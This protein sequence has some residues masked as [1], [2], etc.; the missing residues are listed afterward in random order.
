[1][2]R[3]L[4]GNAALLD[5]VLFRQTKVF[6]GGH[7]AEHRGSMIGRRRGADAGGDVIVAGEDVCNQRAEH[8]EGSAMAEPA[9]ELHVELDL[10]K[11]DMTRTLDHDLDALGPG[12][13]GQLAEGFQLRQ[14]RGI[15]GIGETTW[16][17]AVSQAEGDIVLPHDVT[18]VFKEI[19]HRILLTV[20]QHPLGQ[21]AAAARDDSDQPVLDQRQMLPEHTG[22]KGE[23]VHALLRL[24]LEILENHIV[25]QVL[26][27]APDDHGIDRH[28]ADGRPGVPDE[29]LPAHID[30]APC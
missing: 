10:I 19:V 28:R 23:I 4:V 20:N 12:P 25:G 7:V 17:Q 8:V 24:V 21:Q 27:L 11:G 18:D 15:A 16:T 1:M 3:D 5:I 9:L 14:L 26:Q 30:L 22:V 2:R 13:L 29:G 6:L